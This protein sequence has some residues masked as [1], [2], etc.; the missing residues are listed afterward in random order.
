MIPELVIDKEFIKENWNTPEAAE[1]TI[2]LLDQCVGLK[3]SNFP[4]YM[5]QDMWF[6]MNVFKN[7]KQIEESL[8]DYGYADTEESLVKFLQT[9]ADDKENNYFVYVDL[10]SMDYEKYYKNGS[11]INKDGVDTE[12]D[13]YDYIDE[14]PEMEV[15]QDFENQWIHFAITKIK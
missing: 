3:G 13:Y 7:F 8:C 10:M 2:K 11:Y 4:V 6:K 1:E 12:M 15:P 5:F 9:F 14:H